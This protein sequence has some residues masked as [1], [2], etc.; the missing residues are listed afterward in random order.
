[1]IQE[2]FRF[3]KPCIVL[4]NYIRYHW[5]LHS[6][7]KISQLTFPIG[8]MQL[9]FHKGTP[10]HV[11]TSGSLQNYA[12]V[13]GQ[14]NYP[15]YLKS[16]GNLKMIVTVFEPYAAGCILKLPCNL[17]YNCEVA[18]E[19]LGDRSLNGLSERIIE[20]ENDDT[21]I[22]LIELWLLQRISESHGDLNTNRVRSAVREMNQ[23]PF[24]SLQQLSE[25][26]N[27]SRKQFN[28]IF[29]DMLGMNP[30]EFYRIVRF[31]RALSMMQKK[32]NTV[33]HFSDI[34]YACGFSD[35][36]HMIR[37]FKTF[38]G[39][40]PLQLVKEGSLYSDYFSQPI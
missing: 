15:S 2:T 13:S 30:K 33:D 25:V 27:L 24:V 34:A 28:R 29:I 36:S 26:T 8:C 5:I 39:L 16:S 17:L 11:S 32:T 35:Q 22:K 38:S 7:A 4:E 14:T 10:L 3:I 19:D 37:E 1:M 20:T 40:T 23:N 6:D 9:V 18:A 12:T 21:C 31:Q